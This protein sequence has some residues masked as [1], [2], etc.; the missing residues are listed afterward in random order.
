M[1]IGLGGSLGAIGLIMLL[2]AMYI[3]RRQKR[4][5]KKPPTSVEGKVDAA[6]VSRRKEGAKELP[7]ER[8]IPELMG[9]HS[10]ILLAELDARQSRVQYT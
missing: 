7:A 1:G 4:S 10:Q 9:S 5:Q 3:L 2:L 8:V 6:E